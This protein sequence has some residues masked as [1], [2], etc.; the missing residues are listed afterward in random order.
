MTDKK[1]LDFDFLDANPQKADAMVVAP[2]DLSVPDKKENSTNFFQYFKQC[3]SNFPKFSKEHLDTK[4]PKYLLPV[5]WIVGMGTAADRLTNSGSTTWSEVWAIV[6]L[7]G[8]L[9]GAIAYYIAGWFYYVRV[10]WSKGSGDIDTA[11][12]IYAYSSL[13]VAFVDIGSLVFNQ[14]AYG[15]DY[16]YTYSSDAS[17]VDIIFALLAFAAIVYS[18]TISYRAVREVMHVQKGRAI[19]WFIVLPALFYIAIFASAAFK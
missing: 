12:N 8:I 1:S 4:S 15:N 5:I 11:R 3:F 19:G 2:S 16:F 6:I 10:G 18:I 7:G 14:M 13:A 9:T 17:T